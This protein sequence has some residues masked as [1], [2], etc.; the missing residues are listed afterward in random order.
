MAATA[1]ARAP[2]H[3]F[4]DATLGQLQ[5]A[6]YILISTHG[7]YDPTSK[8]F[9]V[10]P[11]IYIFETQEVSDLCLG[12][13]DSQL[14][15]LLANRPAFMQYITASLPETEY[16]WN[17]VNVFKQFMFYEPGDLIY[18]RILSIGGG[19]GARRNYTMNFA[20]YPSSARTGS[21]N[22]KKLILQDKRFEMADPAKEES[23]QSIIELTLERNPA[24]KNGAVF[25]F[26]SC[27]ATRNLSAVQKEHIAVLQ[28]N[29]LLKFLSYTPIARGG[30]LE[31]PSPLTHAPLRAVEREGHG[32]FHPSAYAPSGLNGYRRPEG[33]YPGNRPK[34]PGTY[35][36]QGRRTRRTQKKKTKNSMFRKSRV[37]TRSKH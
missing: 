15:Y 19:K 14:E 31:E 8:P 23:M 2:T 10:P 22:E 11:N 28:R 9:I 16:N 35:Y 6:P 27:G 18:N 12:T 36:G 30:W 7:V 34:G 32:L 29:A 5:L 26:S 20:A 33:T 21:R 3:A 1:A 17:L 24:L 13:I 25:F 4:P 37:K